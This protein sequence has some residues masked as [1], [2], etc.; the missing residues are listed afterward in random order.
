M[1]RGRCAVRLLFDRSSIACVCDS[2]FTLV[3][4]MTC[5]DKEDCVLH[6]S[7]GI[8]S[9]ITPVVW[10]ASCWRFEWPLSLWNEYSLAMK[11]TKNW[12][13][14]SNPIWRPTPLPPVWCCHSYALNLQPSNQQA[15]MFITHF[16][17]LRENFSLYGVESS[18]NVQCS[19]CYN[20]K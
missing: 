19:F 11:G 2:F 10:A 12:L 9:S 4:R 13:R 15:A 7:S 8:S 20:I 5:S 3:L 17:K 18:T 14:L 6:F 1:L 16:A